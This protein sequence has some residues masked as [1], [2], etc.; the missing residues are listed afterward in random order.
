MER[1]NG[2]DGGGAGY[3]IRKVFFKRQ[4]LFEFLELVMLEN[5]KEFA[6]SRKLLSDF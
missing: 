4:Y 5:R 1:L 2:F 6:R 3:M